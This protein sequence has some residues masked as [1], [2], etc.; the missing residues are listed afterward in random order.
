MY[1]KTVKY[2]QHVKPNL[3]LYSDGF[4]IVIAGEHDKTAPNNVNMTEG[5]KQIVLVNDVIMVNDIF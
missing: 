4:Y 2:V 1:K 5:L 3:L